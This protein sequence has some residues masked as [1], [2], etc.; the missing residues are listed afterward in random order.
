MVECE[1]HTQYGILLIIFKICLNFDNFPKFA[2]LFKLIFELPELK[3][4]W[5]FTS[6]YSIWNVQA[7]K[8]AT[9][10]S[11]AK[12][13]RISGLEEYS[14]EQLFF[15][16]YAYASLLKFSKFYHTSFPIL[17][18]YISI[19]VDGAWPAQICT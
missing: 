14:D 17:L 15:I 13:E 2:P 19:G 6:N 4:I 11:T 12:R 3:Q 9:S 18:P 7:M 5:I 16:N 1:L 8:K 10:E